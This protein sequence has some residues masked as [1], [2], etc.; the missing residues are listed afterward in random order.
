MFGYVRPC[1][2]ELK[3]RELMLF[4]AAYCG[5]CHSLKDTAGIL[6]RFTVNY[7][8][9]V[10]AM[11]LSEAEAGSEGHICRKRCI[12][13]PFRKRPCC[14]KSPAS[15]AVADLSV[16]LLWWK[17]EDS[18]ADDGFFRALPAR[19][20]RLLLRRGMKAARARR[21]TFDRVC[22]EQLGI[23]RQ[24]EE[25]GCSSLDRAADPFALLLS[26]ASEQELDL[27]KRRVLREILYHMGRFVYLADAAADLEEDQKAGRYNPIA[28]HYGANFGQ[29][30]R[31]QLR[32]TLCAS[33]IQAA[34]ALALLEPGPFTP[35]LENIFSLGM[36]ETA[37][38]ILRGD[39]KSVV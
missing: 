22:R 35:V 7:D 10:L 2:A 24:L 4:Q 12:A 18:I 34:N 25:E 11:L 39:R 29:E 17:L 32:E 38:K 16:L 5:L 21:Q 6:A 26:E 33:A 27:R 30:E 31:Q 37:D 1:K 36:P 19:L 8:F 20:L 14:Q 13:S 15:A 28:A 23:L 9:T 3:V